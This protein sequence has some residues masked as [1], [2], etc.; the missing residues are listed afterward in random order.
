[1]C[2]WGENDVKH[3][4]DNKK[5]IAID[6]PHMTQSDADRF[7]SLVSV[8]ATNECWL[9]TGAANANGYGRFRIG[10][11]LYSPHRVAHSLA[12]GDI[13]NVDEFH[14]TVVRHKCDNPPCCNPAHLETGR[15]IDNVA[16]MKERG[17]DDSARGEASGKAKLTEDMVRFIRESQLSSRKLAAELGIV[18]DGTIRQIRR[19]E[20]WAH[21]AANDNGSKKDRA[22]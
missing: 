3:D 15:Q 19:G 16:D 22:A 21:I 11:S 1:M 6:I 13:Q 4:N 2:S 9:W 8:E 18:S 17:R 14:G 20:R 7:W 10:E 12:N 5:S